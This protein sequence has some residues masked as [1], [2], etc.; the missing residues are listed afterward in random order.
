[1]GGNETTIPNEDNKSIESLAS[2]KG[3]DEEN[4][5]SGK[6]GDDL[7]IAL[8]KG[9]RTCVRPIPFAMASY[10][11]YQKVSPQYKAF[12]TQIQEIQ[13][14]KD[15]REALNNSRWKE[16]MDEEMKALL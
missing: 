15:P 12:L 11:D 6:R 1:M 8:R 3:G 14:P 16:A 2:V 13:I 10:L 4:Q 5:N 9:T 7:P